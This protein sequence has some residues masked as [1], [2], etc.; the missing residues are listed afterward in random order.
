[1]NRKITI[2]ISIL[3]SSVTIYAAHPDAAI[4]PLGEEVLASSSTS[5]WSFGIEGLFMLP[6]NANFQYASISDQGVPTRNHDNKSV[7]P[8]HD[9]GGEFDA[10]YHFAGNSRD[11]KVALT[12]IDMDS[13]DKEQLINGRISDPFGLTNIFTDEAKADTDNSVDAIDVVAG[14][15]FNVGERVVMHVFGGIRYADLENNNLAQYFNSQANNA[16]QGS[17]RINTEFDGIGPRAGTDVAVQVG[18]GI[19]IVSTVGV[20]LLKGTVDTKITVAPPA[21]LVGNDPVITD[22]N[23][24]HNLIPEMDAKLGINYHHNINTR[25]A[26]DIQLGYQVVNYFD[27][28]DKDYIDA[29]T[30]NSINNTNDL[31]YRGPYFRA[32]LNI[33]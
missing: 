28:I 3:F 33:V 8:Q 26:F 4:E 31:G 20:S 29:I 10:T 24:G 23:G 32:Q 14:Q 6:T 11:V 19:S 1:M 15:M 9:F 12:H 16:R 21:A 22:N 18:S 25:N 2:G 7:T 17:G 27:V 30:P 5:S 13:S